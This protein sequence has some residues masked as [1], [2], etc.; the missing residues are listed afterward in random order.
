MAR[1]ERYREPAAL[2]AWTR[3]QPDIRVWR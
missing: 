3:S 1:N 2:T